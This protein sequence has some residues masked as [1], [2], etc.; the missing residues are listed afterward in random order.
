MVALECVVCG[1]ADLGGRVV[2]GVVCVSSVGGVAGLHPAG[3]MDV[4]LLRVLC[5]VR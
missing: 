1:L 3:N 2:E 5:V 4:C